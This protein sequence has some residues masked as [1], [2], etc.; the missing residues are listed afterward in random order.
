MHLPGFHHL[1]AVTAEP[2]ANLAFYGQ[3]LGLRLVK[4]TVNQ[5]DVSA[6]HLFFADGA[7]TPGT[8]ITFF[9]WPMTRERRGTGSISRTS[10]RVLPGAMAY[11]ADRLRSASVAVQEA[12]LLTGVPSLE[13]EDPEGQRLAIVA[14]DPAAD[15]ALPSRA[16]ERSPVPAEH[17]L[18]GLGPIHLALSELAPTHALLTQVLNATLVKSGGTRHVYTTAAGSLSSQVHVAVDATLPAAR[19]GAGGVHHVAFRAPTSEAYDAWHARLREARVPVSAK[20]DRF[21][22]RSIYFRDPSGILYEI[23]TDSPGFS[24]DEP[25]ETMGERLSLPPFLEPR[26]AQI[27]AGLKPL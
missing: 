24:A 17:Q 27:Q 19:Q 15:T 18:R 4:K 6:Y 3:V 2:K 13:F 21:Y 16:W 7:G 5:D 25:A 8:D 12:E 10:Y 26:R 14:E 11:W 20:I 23:A 22:F 9:D 1:T